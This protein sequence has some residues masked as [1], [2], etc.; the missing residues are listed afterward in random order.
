MTYD[1]TFIVKPDS[2]W[3]GQNSKLVSHLN[4]QSKTIQC[5][6]KLLLTFK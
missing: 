4:E 6:E 2:D 1:G 5:V 3:L